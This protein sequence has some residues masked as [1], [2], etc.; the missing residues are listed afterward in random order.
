L[1]LSAPASRHPKQI[2]NTA[3]P[4][5]CPMARRRS[6][7]LQPHAR[8]RPTPLPGYSCREPC[9]KSRISLRRIT[10]KPFLSSPPPWHA[11][12]P[13]VRAGELAMLEVHPEI[14]APEHTEHQKVS[15]CHRCH[16]RF[17]SKNEDQFCL[18]LWGPRTTKKRKRAQLANNWS[19]PALNNMKFP[20]CR[21][22]SARQRIALSAR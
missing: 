10:N 5:L 20:T 15:I 7:I 9:V 14:H 13:F 1:D 2:Q 12:C 19:I 8:N 21:R 11:V 3:T 17:R 18:Q 16:R 4:I 6:N 22:W